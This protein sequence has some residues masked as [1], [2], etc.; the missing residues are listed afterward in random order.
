[1]VNIQV[2]YKLH[3]LNT[4]RGVAEPDQEIVDSWGPHTS[5]PVVDFRDT[6]T[7]WVWIY[8]DLCVELDRELVE[9]LQEGFKEQ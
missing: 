7:V 3:G 1:M 5:E 2:R 9:R 4:G 8:D 6:E